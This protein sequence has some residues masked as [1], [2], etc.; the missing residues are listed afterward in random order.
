M[1]VSIERG[2]IMLEYA[3]NKETMLTTREVSVLLNVHINTVRRWSNDGLIKG[4]RVC[5]K[6]HRRFYLKDV[7]MFLDPK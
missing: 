6:G 2:I 5:S 3:G 4:Y 7:E 1:P